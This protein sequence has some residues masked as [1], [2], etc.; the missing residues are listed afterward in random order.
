MVCKVSV[1]IATLLVVLFVLWPDINNEQ[2]SKEEVTQGNSE[3]S[4]HQKAIVNGIKKEANQKSVTV[5]DKA[6]L[7]SEEQY[8]LNQMMK[9]VIQAEYSED[10]FIEASVQQLKFFGCEMFSQGWLS[11]D[12]KNN[13]D[14]EWVSK[15]TKKCSADKKSRPNLYF[16]S[17][18]FQVY[19]HLPATSGWGK[20]LKA[21][22]ELNQIEKQEFGKEF[23]RF[24]LRQKQAHWLLL[25]MLQSNNSVFNLAQ[26]LNT[27]N[28]LY[29]RHIESAAMMLL[30]C[31]WDDGD[32]CDSTSFFMLTSCAN[33]PG[34]CGMSYP[35]WFEK[36]HMP[37]VKKDVALVLANLN[38]FANG[39]DVE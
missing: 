11:H 14:A 16:Q 19:A 1:V 24:A 6:K 32:L 2:S 29:M 5:E 31:D 23:L 39:E 13:N 22:R 15:T 34:D 25:A 26:W 18:K 33:T 28:T 9:E 27:S 35:Q 7:N 20:R 38:A 12:I 17:K 36:N 21:A 37:G 4:E 8:K 3:P 10:P 30:M